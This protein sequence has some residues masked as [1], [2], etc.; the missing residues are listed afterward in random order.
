[1]RY[2]GSRMT[3]LV[4]AG[5]GLAASFVPG[6]AWAG[7]GWVTPMLGGLAIFALLFV[8]GFTLAAVLGRR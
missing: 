6:V 7:H 5:A 8:A 2:A 4:A 3:R 1:M